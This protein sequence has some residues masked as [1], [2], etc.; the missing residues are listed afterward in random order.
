[1]QIGDI[2]IVNFKNLKGDFVMLKDLERKNDYLNSKFENLLL[3]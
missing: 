3:S 1:M 2:S